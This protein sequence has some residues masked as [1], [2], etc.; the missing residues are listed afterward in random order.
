MTFWRLAFVFYAIALFTATHWPKMVI[1]P[2]SGLR[3]D[4]LVHFAAYGL[5]TLLISRAGFFAHPW[6]SARNIW[7]SALGAAAFAG[8]DEI[9]Q[10]IPGVGRVSDWQDYA[11]NLTGIL[12]GAGALFAF[13][14]IVINRSPQKIEAKG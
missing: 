1:N 9:T 6:H 4:I 2:A 5:F 11:A 12:T 13:A 3:V 8:G 10:S 14:R 7:L